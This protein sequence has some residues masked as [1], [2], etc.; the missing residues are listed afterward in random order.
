MPKYASL[1][2]R[3]ANEGSAAWD[4]LFQAWKDKAA[5]ED[6][7]ILAVGDPD[8]N[9]PQKIIDSAKQAMDAGHTH[10]IDIPGLPDLREAVADELM[11]VSGVSTDAYK[12]G[13]ANV[14]ICQGTQNALFAASLCL[15]EEGDEIIALEPMYLTYQATFE[16]NGAKLVPVACPRET[17]FRPQPELIEKAITANTRAILFANPNN[18]T[19]AVFTLAELEAIADI[20]KRHDLWV[21]ADEVYA[22]QVYDGKH[23]S[24]AALPGMAERTVTCGSLSKAFAMTGWRVGWVAGSEPFIHHCHNAGI[25]MHYGVSAF[26]QHASVTA[27]RDC[28]KDVEDMR[29]I[30]RRRCN[31]VLDKLAGAPGLHPIAPEGAMY[32]LLD[33]TGTGYGSAEFA[34]ELYRNE[35]VAVLDAKPFGPSADGCVRIA[36]T[37]S[38]E[39]I[40]EACE[41][42]YRFAASRHNEQKAS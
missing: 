29:D 41:R 38:D 9:T 37:I 8:F 27:L 33:V 4:I 30:Y 22:G 28:Q 5:G 34:A 11:R 16:I 7:I 24:M 14:M 25:A 3:T 13:P 17:G 10:Y 39:D 36:F 21:I 18:P 23:H 20:A 31:I 32:V 26:I 15:L 35:K 42:I 40:A 6:V 19:G 12:V 1:I 2:S